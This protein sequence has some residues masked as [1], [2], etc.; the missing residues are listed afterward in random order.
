MN[1]LIIDTEVNRLEDPEVIEL[2]V[3][4][5][6]IKEGILHTHDFACWRF[7]PTG[8]IEPGAMAVHHILPHDLQN[9][10]DSA[11]A[12]GALP[13]AEYVIGH[14]I[15]FDANALGLTQQKRI[16]TLALVRSMFP[17]WKS[18][19]L[20]ACIYEILGPTENA[21]RF[22]KDSHNALADVMS[23]ELLLRKILELLRPSSM[24]ELFRESENARIPKVMPFGKHKGM[25][26]N[27][28]PLSY[29]EWLRKQ[30]DV[31]QYLRI[32][33]KQALPL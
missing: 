11:S 30:E 1:A 9:C 29:L 27:D 33:I 17:S 7:K 13:D 5:A 8:D 23:T 31:D 10:M 18:H 4:A 24:E 28:V 25:A 26:I 22:A 6:E 20:G 32:A 19:T 3:M 21:R 14:N 15:D 12:A 2:A 16:C